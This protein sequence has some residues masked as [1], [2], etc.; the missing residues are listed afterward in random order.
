MTRGNQRD[1]AREKN[2]KEAAA[3]VMVSSAIRSAPKTAMTDQARRRRRTP[4]LARNSK[5]PKKMPRPSCGRSRRE[6]C[7]FSLL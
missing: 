3:Q 7:C 2:L 4:C 1:K 5:R 6:V